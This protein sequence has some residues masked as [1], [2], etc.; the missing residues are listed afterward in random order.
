M[1]V[2]KFGIRENSRGDGFHKGGNGIVREIEFKCPVTLSILSERRVH[3]PKGLKGG[4]NGAR[5]ANYLIGKGKRKIYI[6]GKN[7]VQAQAGDI[8][9]IS[10]P[11]GGGRGSP[12]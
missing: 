7:T 11:G 10:T 5:G 12:K 9:Q 6:G 2:H 3:A 8:I 4:K 1:V